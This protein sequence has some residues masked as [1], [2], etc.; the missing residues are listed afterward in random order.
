MKNNIISFCFLGLAFSACKSSNHIVR[1]PSE[2]KIIPF[3]GIDSVVLGVST[4]KDIKKHIGK[5]RV[6][7]VFRSNDFPILLG[8]FIKEIRYPELGLT[9]EVSASRGKFSKK[10]LEYITIDSTSKIKTNTGVGIGSGYFDVIKEIGNQS[11]SRNLHSG[12]SD[13]YYGKINNYN[14]FVSLYFFCYQKSDTLTFRVEQIW[15]VR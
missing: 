7:T 4:V 8:E 13:L 3:Q 1:D 6:R 5:A 11:L 10:T 12:T 14:N 15:M 2:F 9:F